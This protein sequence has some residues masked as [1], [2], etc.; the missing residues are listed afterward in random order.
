MAE[1]KQAATRAPS[2]KYAFMLLSR[3]VDSTTVRQL[4]IYTT[5]L[6]VRAVDF[7][8]LPPL[9]ITQSLR[10]SGNIA[11][12]VPLGRYLTSSLFPDRSA[13]PSKAD[14][15]A[16]GAIPFGHESFFEPNAKIESILSAGFFPPHLDQKSM[17]TLTFAKLRARDLSTRECARISRQGSR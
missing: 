13:F 8:A 16:S 5:Q 7:V 9:R 15:N 17:F 12:G 4:R 14:I 1:V 10:K 3:Q 2:R 11:T 6:A